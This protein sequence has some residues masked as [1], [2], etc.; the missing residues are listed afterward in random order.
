MK[1]LWLW[2][3]A[4]TL[5]LGLTVLGLPFVLVVLIASPFAALA[6]WNLIEPLPQRHTCGW[7]G[8]RFG[9]PYDWC[10]PECA[11]KELP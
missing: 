8:R 5:V 6:G 2:I 3:V 10:C 11:L 4:C 9:G 7:C 1:A